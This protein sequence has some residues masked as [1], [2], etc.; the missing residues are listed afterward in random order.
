MKNIYILLI[1]FMVLLLAS[2]TEEPVGQYPVDK[3]APSPVSDVSVQDFAGYSEITYTIPQ[4]QD[5]LYVAA[6]YTNSVGEQTEVRASA[7]TN[8]LVVYGFGRGGQFDVELVAVD[9]SDN[10]SSAVNVAINPEDSP[11]YSIQESM[12]MFEAFG[13]IKI[14]WDNPD[15]VGIIIEIVAQDSTGTYESLQKI[16]GS[17]AEGKGAVRG[18]ESVER[19]FGVVIQD[20]FKNSTDTLFATLTPLFEEMLDKS[21]HRTMPISPRFTASKY[22]GPQQKVWDD[23]VYVPQANKAGAECFDLY[24]NGE[25]PI[26]WNYDLGVTAKLSRFKMWARSS[27]FYK[28]AHPRH[29][30]IW[31]TTDPDVASDTESFDGWELLFE[32]RTDKVSGNDE[33]GPVTPEDFE[34]AKAGEEFEMG[35]PVP[36]ARFIRFRTLETWGN[37]DRSW[38]CELTWWGQVVEEH[39]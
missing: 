15:R 27:H 10:E 37:M 3:E 26:Y 31:G 4:D 29:F 33:F 35:L 32:V 13:G 19:K 14:N 9:K 17:V 39:N 24:G 22:G 18:L 30:Q 38:L 8:K 36:E 16:Y 7:Y 20:A 28:L 21:L 11:I 25:D 23:V 12:E 34:H 2:C 6:H 5:L 1:G